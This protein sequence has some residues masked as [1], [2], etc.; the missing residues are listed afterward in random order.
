MARGK[1]A[2]IQQKQTQKNTRAQGWDSNPAMQKPCA[3]AATDPSSG[4][5]S[6]TLQAVGAQQKLLHTFV[7]SSGSWE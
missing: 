1:S 6:N 4:L 3:L 2:P 5:P 7:I